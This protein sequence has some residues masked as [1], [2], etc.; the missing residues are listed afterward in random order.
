E[1]PAIEVRRRR[2]RDRLARRQRDDVLPLEERRQLVELLPAGGDELSRRRVLC[3]GLRPRG[4]RVAA[5]HLAGNGTEFVL[6]R[7]QLAGGDR[8]Q[9]I[10]RQGHTL[11]EAQLL[12]ELV[13]PE[14]ERAARLRREIVFERF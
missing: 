8:E 14:P 11:F 9:A 7:L 10:E 1:R 5:V 4:H 13:A 2:D 3:L 6:G 12:L